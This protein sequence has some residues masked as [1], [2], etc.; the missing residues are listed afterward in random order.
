MSGARWTER[1]AEWYDELAAEMSEPAV[2]EPVV[3]FLAQLVAKSPIVTRMSW[4]PGF[5]LSF[6][7]IG[8]EMSMPSTGTPR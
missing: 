5:A 2:L 8:A 6:A 1:D 7:T 4:P 3:D